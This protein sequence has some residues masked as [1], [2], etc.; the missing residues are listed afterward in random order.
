[1][2]TLYA[3][4]PFLYRDFATTDLNLDFALQFVGK[5]IKPHQ[6]AGLLSQSSSH[7]S[8]PS[9]AGYRET[10]QSRIY[11]LSQDAGRYRYLTIPLWVY[12]WWLGK[13]LIKVLVTI[14]DRDTVSVILKWI[15]YQWSV[16][17]FSNRGS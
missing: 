11:V 1:M 9:S 5:Q 15:H 17:S 2:E 7:L 10:E 16:P 8:V 13:T 3:Q 12:C 6:S 4:E 14:F